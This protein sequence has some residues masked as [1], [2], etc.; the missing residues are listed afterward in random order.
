MSSWFKGSKVVTVPQLK[1]LWRRLVLLRGTQGSWKVWWVVGSRREFGS[2][3]EPE[4][5]ERGGLVRPSRRLKESER[6]GGRGGR[7]DLQREML[8]VIERE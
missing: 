5:E 2:G 7:L 4:E 3:R 6:N 1:P 8:R